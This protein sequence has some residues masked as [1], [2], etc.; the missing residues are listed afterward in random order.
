MFIIH[1][2]DT[3]ARQPWEYMAAA[4]GTYKAGQ[5]LTV[6]DGKAAP[7]TAALKTTPPYIC[8][9]DVTVA[10]GQVLP[11]IRTTDKAIYATELS[12]EA[13]AAKVGT[14]LEVSAGGLQVDAT[15][16]GTFEVTDIEGT[17]AGSAVYGRFI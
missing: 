3:G 11:V 16:T 9:A 8:M 13:A 12:A 6:T 17:A 5:A 2:H 7:I 1:K 4:A 15:A 10:D 14:K